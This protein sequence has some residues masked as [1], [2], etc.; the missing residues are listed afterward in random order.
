MNFT[1]KYVDMVKKAEIVITTLL[2][3]DYI[4]YRDKIYKAEFGKL[5]DEEGNYI[6]VPEGNYYFFP[7]DPNKFQELYM[8]EFSLSIENKQTIDV[9][10]AHQVLMGLY[11]EGEKNLDYQFLKSYIE[12]FETE[13]E[14][15]LAI[16]QYLKS[17]VWTDNKWEFLV[18]NKT[19]V[20]Q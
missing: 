10:L 8:L 3:G 2:D 9:D 12:V 5:R 14:K 1:E 20:I 7:C 19:G 6:D 13:E 16:Y 15:G 18:K 11:P 4:I 17:L